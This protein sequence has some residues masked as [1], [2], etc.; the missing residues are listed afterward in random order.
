MLGQSGNQGF[1]DMKSES[2]PVAGFTPFRDF[3]GHDNRPPL[4]LGG[5]RVHANERLIPHARRRGLRQQTV[6]VRFLPEAAV[7]LELLSTRSSGFHPM[8]LEDFE[9]EYG[10]GRSRRMH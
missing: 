2:L 5:D 6:D 10:S 4:S 3:S 1:P 8:D 7:S 9:L